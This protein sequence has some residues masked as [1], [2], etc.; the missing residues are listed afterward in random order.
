MRHRNHAQRLARKPHQSRSILKNLVTSVL[1]YERVRTT[2]K[3][4]Q[5]VRPLVDRVISIGKNEPRADLAIR[6]INLMVSDANACRKVLEVLKNRYAK[7]TSGFTRMLPVGQR[8]GDGAL[9]VDLELVDAAEPVVASEEKAPKRIDNGK[10]KM[11][12]SRSKKK[13]S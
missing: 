13:K 1:L 10:L 8:E 3:R 12:N 9:M 5:V 2:K 11:D 4:A 6:K 7:R